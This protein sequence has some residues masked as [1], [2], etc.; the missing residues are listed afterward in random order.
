MRTVHGNPEKMLMQLDSRRDELLN[1][2]P[3]DPYDL[4]DET[5]VEWLTLTAERDIVVC[6]IFV[7]VQCFFSF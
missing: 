7:K 2:I 1:D 6:E 4:P 3:L 5:I